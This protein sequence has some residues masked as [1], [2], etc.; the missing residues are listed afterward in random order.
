[1]PH[2]V[3]NCYDNNIVEQVRDCSALLWHHSHSDPRDVVIAQQILFAH[4]H[5]GFEVFPDFRLAWHFDDKVGQK[6]LFEALD[7]P[8]LPSYVFVHKNTALEW[9]ATTDYPKVFKLRHGASSSCVRLV[10]SESQARGLIK[11]AFGRGFPVYSLWDNL[12][13]RFY[14]SRLKGFDAVELSK[15]FGRFLYPPRFSQVLGRQNGYVLFQ[16]FAPGNDSDYRIV[17]VGNRAFGARRWVRPGD[18]RASGSQLFTYEPEAIDIECVALAFQLAE[19]L[20]GRCLAFDFVRKEDG[21]LP[22]IEVSYGFRWKGNSTGHWDRNL[23]WHTCDYR[24]EEW[25]VD[26]VLESCRARQIGG[27]G[28]THIGSSAV[29][30]LPCR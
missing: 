20:G 8:R 18:F 7:I 24:P 10:R 19:K 2:K 22:V 17:V 25:M 26:L 28:Q 23:Q 30:N 6:Y 13:E 16:D 4:M 1:L 15:G 12:K 5:A 21:S 29:E 9:A 14:R 11:R 27:D 3:V